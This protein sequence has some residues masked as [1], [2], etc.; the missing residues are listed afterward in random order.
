METYCNAPTGNKFMLIPKLFSIKDNN[1]GITLLRVFKQNQSERK[2]VIPFPTINTINPRHE[3][4][5][6]SQEKK[7]FY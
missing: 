6:S 1:T 4:S 5:L 2:W 7:A 3:I